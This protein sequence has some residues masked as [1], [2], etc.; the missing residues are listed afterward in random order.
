MHD[1]D[2]Y[3]ASTGNG[4]ETGV[5]VLDVPP[6][7][8]GVAVPDAV[9]DGM[10]PAED[11]GPDACEGQ[12]APQGAGG[13][14]PTEGS[15]PVGVAGAPSSAPAQGEG[16]EPPRRKPLVELTRRELGDEGEEWAARRLDAHGWTI[17][18]RNWRCKYGEVDIV[19]LDD[20][21]DP[22]HEV[23]V[24]VEVKTRLS[25]GRDDVVPEVAVDTRKQQRYRQLGRCYLAEHPEVESVRFDVIAIVVSGEGK[26]KLRHI[27]SAF[28]LEER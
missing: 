8:V 18:E 13:D 10:A 12:P 22:E 16:S 21:T 6:Q 25:R 5:G 9:M 15:A 23:A 27:K 1:V 7:P 14:V 19:A 28:V 4:H 3:G 11:E 24:L 2:E 20:E 17:L 26:A